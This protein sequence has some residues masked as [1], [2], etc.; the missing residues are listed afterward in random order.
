MTVV[1]ITEHARERLRERFGLRSADAAAREVEQALDAGR[2]AAH[3]PKW[4]GD[5][6]SRKGRRPGYGRIRWCWTERRDRTYV[7]RRHRHRDVVLTAMSPMWPDRM[8][9]DAP[10]EEVA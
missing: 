7:I 2:M 5:R 9:F 8:P 4:L 3:Q 10:D 6:N 1:V